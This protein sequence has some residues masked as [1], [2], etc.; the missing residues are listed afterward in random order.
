MFLKLTNR[1]LELSGVITFNC[2]SFMIFSAL[3]KLAF[4]N[5]SVISFKMA[6]STLFDSFCL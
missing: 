4:D 5:S 3:E 1:F 2:K 6:W